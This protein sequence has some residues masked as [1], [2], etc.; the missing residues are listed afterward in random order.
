MSNREEGTPVNLQKAEMARVTAIRMAKQA[1]AACA[2]GDDCDAEASD[3]ATATP[4]D[5]WLGL[6][7]AA[8]RRESEG[9]KARGAVGGAA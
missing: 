7:C 1:K 2:R 5:G 9:A 3:P 4:K 8:H 6:L